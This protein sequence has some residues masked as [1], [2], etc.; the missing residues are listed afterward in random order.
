MLWCQAVF[1][2]AGAALSVIFARL[3][4]RIWPPRNR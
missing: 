3:F 4:D 2:I 1:A